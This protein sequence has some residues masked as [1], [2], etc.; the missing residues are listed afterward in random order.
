MDF[1]GT[2]VSGMQWVALPSHTPWYANARV[3]FCPETLEIEVP[4]KRARF[5]VI[6]KIST[7]SGPK[8]SPGSPQQDKH[9]GETQ[10]GTTVA[11]KKNRSN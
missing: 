8:N 7:V 10:G 3:I 9:N 6:A 5:G 11:N 4:A 1:V 2:P